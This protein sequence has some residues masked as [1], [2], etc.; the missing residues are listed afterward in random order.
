MLPPGCRIRNGFN[1]C[2]AVLAMAGRLTT[3]E[4]IETCLETAL[5]NFYQVHTLAGGSTSITPISDPA[6]RIYYRTEIAE[7]AQAADIDKTYVFYAVSSADANFLTGAVRNK[8]SYRIESRAADHHVAIRMDTSAIEELRKCN[9]LLSVTGLVDD[10][11]HD[12][13]IHRRISTIEVPA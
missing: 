2:G 5:G 4:R 6:G 11:D 13:R 1:R 10:Y 8:I 12:L 3:E 7:G 9:L